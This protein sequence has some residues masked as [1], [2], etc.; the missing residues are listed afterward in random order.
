MKG[1]EVTHTLRCWHPRCACRIRNNKDA[2][3]RHTTFIIANPIAATGF[4]YIIRPYV[5][6][7]VNRK[8]YRALWL[9]FLH[10]LA[11]TAWWWLL[12]AAETCSCYWICYNSCVSTEYVLIMTHS[13]PLCALFPL[14]GG[15]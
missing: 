14:L 6:E 3:R 8:L 13:Y 1:L 7:K 15:I 10:F 11:H 9:S 4:G 5:S 2:V 12:G